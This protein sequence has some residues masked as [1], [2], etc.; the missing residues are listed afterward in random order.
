MHSAPFLTLSSMPMCHEVLCYELIGPWGRTVFNVKPAVEDL[1]EVSP[2][3]SNATNGYVFTKAMFFICR[4]LWC[5]KTVGQPAPIRGE[6]QY[7]W[8][9]YDRKKKISTEQS[10]MTVRLYLFVCAADGDG[11]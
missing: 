7:N 5:K 9:G 4:Y 6:H 1:P 3:E 8:C 2:A 10:A 11:V